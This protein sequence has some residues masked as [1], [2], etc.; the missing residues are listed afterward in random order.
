MVQTLVFASFLLAAPPENNWQQEVAYR[1]EVE[2]DTVHHMLS[3]REE[4]L[5][6]NNSPDT[7]PEL[8][9]HLYPNA[10]RDRASRFAK[11]AE[12][13]GQFRFSF[14]G[15]KDRGWIEIDSVF[16]GGSDMS[17]RAAVLEDTITEMVLS[18][19]EPL[20][21]GNSLTIVLHFRVKIPYLF[22]RLGR[23]RN[24]YEITQWY[25]KPVVYDSK[26]WHPDG[27][28][29]LGEFYGEYGTYDVVI[30][31]P[32]TMQIG[33]TGELVS[34]TPAGSGKSHYR[35]HA[36]K[37]HDFAFICDPYYKVT[38]EYHGNT[39]VRVLYFPREEKEWKKALGYAKDALTYY[40]RW[41]GEY[42]YST[43]TVAQGFR[44]TGGGM[45]YPN[46]VL[47]SIKP[48]S[49]TNLF[50][51][52]VMHEVGHQ[53]F[54]GV[55]GNNEM[56]EAWLDE[57]INTFSEIRYMEEKYGKD[58]KLFNFPRLLRFLSPL[59]ARYLHRFLYHTA[60]QYE[61][62]SILSPA[63]RFTEDP[64]SYSAIAYS[65]AGLVVD[66]LRKYVG[67]A[68]FDEIM[69]TYVKRFSYKHP[70][71]RDFIDVVNEVTGEDMNWFFD[72]W[73]RTTEKCDYEVSL[74]SRGYRHIVK[75][76][77]Q[78]NHRDN[79]RSRIRIKRHG[80]N[81]MPLELQLIYANEEEQRVLIE[82]DFTDTTIEVQ[83]FVRSVTIDPD[84]KILETN[85]WNN[86]WPRKRS[87]KPV[88]D[89]PDFDAYQ[90][91]Y[92]PYMWYQ[93]VDGIQVGGGLQGR[94]FLPMEQFHGSNSWDYHAVFGT[95]SKSFLHGASYSFPIRKPLIARLEL[96]Y[97]P[98]EGR[99]KVSL[100]RSVFHGLFSQPTHKFLLSY[101][102]CWL[103]GY[104][105]KMEK[106]WE[107]SNLHIIEVSYIYRMRTRRL[108]HYL[109]PQLIYGTGDLDFTR[110]SV[111][112]NE[113]IR[114]TWNNGFTAKLYAGYIGGTPP[115]QYRFYPSGSLFP[116]GESPFALTYEGRFSPLEHWHIEGG[117]D[118]K[119]Y[120]G[121]EMSGTGALTASLCTP[122]LLSRSWFP[123]TVFFD[124]GIL[125]DENGDT[126]M[127]YDAGVTLNIGPL[128]MDFPLWV[129]KPAAD[130]KKWAF[131]WSIGIAS[132]T[133]SFF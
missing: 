60:S 19:P 37:V 7:L 54:Y 25:P 94:Q 102:H 23:I 123:S 72:Q 52:V 26:G 44:G 89:F 95:K 55:V 43:L 36:E 61:E 48:N 58:E 62:R 108:T 5:Y 67:E 87:I 90:I 32:D 84:R 80:E 77:G 20:P 39:L 65:K 91:F 16:A 35:F 133:V 29:A 126:G 79:P 100:T 8:R 68:T 64:A 47:L 33:A 27:Y 45:E 42:P 15:E 57:G 10:Y 115:R 107:A 110:V 128:F 103:G 30:T 31:L 14:S 18:L 83:E 122:Y 24:H 121:R 40:G 73:L 78:S 97:N 76:G 28:R 125:F 112:I 71:T 86:H 109:T 69:R 106:Y 93:T 49:L 132:S 82:G 1:I 101:E 63:Y 51:T 38:S 11:D 66:M 2:L 127:L 53:W 21:P 56:D 34:V 120:Y 17:D 129:S 111:R 99:E 117:P 124:T 22:S 96:G 104:R 70:T 75:W 13:M 46:I 113:F 81:I 12:R 50:E 98:V 88:F 118:L 59:N 41:Y 105:Y 4:L 85:R 130:E 3:G 131:R 9:F 119:G 114:T 74:I 92:Y 6:A 116:T